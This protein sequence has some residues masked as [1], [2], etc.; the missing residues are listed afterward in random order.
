MASLTRISLLHK[1]AEE[2]RDVSRG[3][4]L[5]DDTIAEAVP[6][7]R[8]SRALRAFVC[9]CLSERESYHEFSDPGALS[10]G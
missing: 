4:A 8:F 5:A 2:A 9:D 10:H 3:H 6:T 7:L 1:L